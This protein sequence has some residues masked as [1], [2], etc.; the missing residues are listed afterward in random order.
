M[1][2]K[3]GFYFYFL[4]VSFFCFQNDL[5][6]GPR[7]PCFSEIDAV[8]KAIAE[9]N[10]YSLWQKE[11]N[12]A[13]KK[14]PELKGVSENEIRSLYFIDYKDSFAEL[15]SLASGEITLGE[16]K[17]IKLYKTNPAN[18]PFKN[19]VNVMKASKAGQIKLDLEGLK[20]F[21][22]IL[23]D[24]LLEGAEAKELGQIRGD[25]LFGKIYKTEA[26]SPL[27]LEEIKKN[28]YITFAEIA[29][30]DKGLVYG[31]YEYPNVS[32]LTDNVK[33]ILKKRNPEF[34]I[35]IKHI[36]NL[37]QVQIFKLNQKL[38]THLLEDLLEWF[39][40]KRSEIGPLKNAQDIKKYTYLSSEFQRKLVSIHPFVDGNG[41]TSRQF[42][43]Y[44]PLMLEELPLPR[45]VDVDSDI[46]SPIHLWQEQVSKGVQS[47]LELE[48][49]LA[50]RVKSGLQIEY[51][52]ELLL[53]WIPEKVSLA[54]RSQKPL[55]NVADKILVDV[56]REQYLAFFL[57]KVEMDSKY[58]KGVIKN[59]EK[60]LNE[61]AEDY[62]KFVDTSQKSFVHEKKGS[63]RIGIY[64]VGKDFAESFANTS[65]HDLSSWSFKMSKYY[66]E[67][68]IWRGL[69]NMKKVV[70]DKEILKM[71]SEVSGHNLSNSVL[72]KNVSAN[73]AQGRKLIA[74]DFSQYNKDLISGRFEKMAQDHCDS[75]ELYSK[76]Y[77]LS[78]SKKRAVGKAF[79]MGA[80]VIAPY[81]Q[82][83]KFQHLLK[84]RLLVGSRRAM[85]D[86]DFSRLKQLRPNFSY[87]YPRQQEVMAIGAVDPD[88]VMVAQTID[89]HGEVIKSFVRNSQKPQEIWV[90]K[91]EYSAIPKSRDYLLEIIT[92][93]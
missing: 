53:P 7:G 30:T 25:A 18:I 75:G 66:S 73:S 17:L 64:F 82:Q 24:K 83:G 50:R 13:L 60:F 57:T 59:S 93:D 76:S 48:K 38:I 84:S 40:L 47:S 52:P 37:D 90:L 22:T 62:Q 27:A 61:V 5:Y 77:G 19:F 81:G 3:M 1:L 92:L 36:H 42:S 72:A 89:A 14:F 91:G 56:D 54:Y 21:H 85:K 23:M 33:A 32:N 74:R 70:S 79:A 31:T 34:L 55:V 44:Y 8:F 11:W 68:I 29:K 45:L 58:A 4:I 39:T 9:G 86:V 26:I 80:M 10:N 65:Y 71:F 20:K 6:A 88:A 12:S 16:D 2:K 43:L 87:S 15:L 46:F 51:T 67:E 63:E 78:T 35:E 28:P 49:S 41:R 69:S